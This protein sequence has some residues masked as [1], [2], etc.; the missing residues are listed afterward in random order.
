M[1]E[2]NLIALKIHKSLAVMTCF[3]NPIA[4]DLELS[5]TWAGRLLAGS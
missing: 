3:L 2:Q 4:V 5:R 1:T